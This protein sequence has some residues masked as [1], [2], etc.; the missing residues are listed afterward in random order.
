MLFYFQIALGSL[1]KAEVLGVASWFIYNMYSSFFVYKTASAKDNP[2]YL[3]WLESHEIRRC[4]TR[5]PYVE[6]HRAESVPPVSSI[7]PQVSSGRLSVCQQPSA[8][9]LLFLLIYFLFLLCSATPGWAP[10]HQSNQQ[11]ATPP[12]SAAG[13]RSFD[14]WVSALASSGEGLW[15][16]RYRRVGM[17][18]RVYL[19]P[20]SVPSFSPVYSYIRRTC[21]HSRTPAELEL[22]LPVCDQVTFI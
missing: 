10:L 6:L 14:R 3:M 20:F 16:S 13:D 11:A 4:E 5:L 15:P 1:F 19:H 17:I 7:S 21:K 18:D 22:R 9:S 12:V 2:T 8:I